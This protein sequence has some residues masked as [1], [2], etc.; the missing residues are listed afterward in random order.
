ML[1]VVIQMTIQKCGHVL[2][3]CNV[4]VP[5]VTEKQ[6]QPRIAPGERGSPRGGPQIPREHQQAPP[7]ATRTNSKPLSLAKFVTAA[8]TFD[9]TAG[10][11]PMETVEARG[12]VGGTGRR[13]ERRFQT[14][15]DDEEVA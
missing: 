15:W 14:T 4:I 11:G 1:T 3:S 9:G 8:E 12:Q 7:S 2:V 13:A 10:P 5:M 6:G